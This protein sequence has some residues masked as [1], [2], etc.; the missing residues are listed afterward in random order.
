MGFSGGQS[1]GASSGSSYGY[2]QSLAQSM[3]GVWGPQVGQLVSMYG[4]AGALANQQQQTVPVAAKALSSQVQPAAQFGLNQMQQFANPNSALAQRQTADL[5]DTVGTQFNRTIMPGITS[6]A[7]LGG[8]IGGSR[9]ALAQ[10]VAAGDAARA[11]SS[12][13]TDFFTNVY[14]QAGQ[15]AQALPGMAAGVY[16]LG[17]QPFQSAWAPLSSMAGILGGPTVLSQSQ[18]RSQA[19]NASWQKSQNEGWQGGFN[20]W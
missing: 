14:N 1:S 5:A 15:A 12:G 11:I 19:E 8:N 13:A 16:N 3:Q 4:Q 2:N 6:A 20:L 9:Q 7:G 18:A 10:G 17:M